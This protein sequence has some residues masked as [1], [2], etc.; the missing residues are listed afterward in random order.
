MHVKVG[1]PFTLADLGEGPNADDQ[2]IAD[3]VMRRIAELLPY[4]MRGEYSNVH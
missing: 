1:K 4:E 2:A 3:G